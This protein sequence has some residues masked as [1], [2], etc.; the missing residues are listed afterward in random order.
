MGNYEVK[1]EDLTTIT[2]STG[3]GY[4]SEP[5]RGNGGRLQ[6]EHM[7][8]QGEPPGQSKDHHYPQG[9]GM[10]N[11]GHGVRVVSL[12][13]VTPSPGQPLHLAMEGSWTPDPRVY[14]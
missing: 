9:Q 12:P 11:S 14:R 1:P 5:V 4:S 7:A 2:T 13:P 10:G 6:T 3:L 8:L